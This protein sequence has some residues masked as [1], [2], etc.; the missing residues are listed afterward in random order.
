MVEL[1]KA[2]TSERLDSFRATIKLS[3]TSR[4]IISGITKEQPI[5][6]NTPKTH[7]LADRHL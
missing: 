6:S 7:Y 1:G 4:E 2:G 3:Q 5:I